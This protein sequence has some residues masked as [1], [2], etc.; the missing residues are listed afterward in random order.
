[1][2]C[3]AGQCICGCV[4]IWSNGGCDCAVLRVWA[5][6]V[7]HQRWAAVSPGSLAPD[8]AP[9]QLFRPLHQTFAKCMQWSETT[10]NLQWVAGIPL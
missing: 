7:A 8:A 6:S 1:M 4:R 5:P 3:R 10:S 9:R 2:C